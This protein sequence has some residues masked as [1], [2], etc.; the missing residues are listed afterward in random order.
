MAVPLLC[1]LAVGALEL[2]ALMGSQGATKKP[3]EKVSGVIKT[4]VVTLLVFIAIFA[5]FHAT[6]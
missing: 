3:L 5:A 1:A 2:N 6:T 4:A